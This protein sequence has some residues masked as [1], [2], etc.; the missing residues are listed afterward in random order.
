MT[1]EFK[2][3][4]Y[5]KEL[6]KIRAASFKQQAPREPQATS[7]EPEPTGPGSQKPQAASSKHR[8]PL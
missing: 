4:K 5:Y 1:H 8:D 7:T 6:R 3:P 2:H